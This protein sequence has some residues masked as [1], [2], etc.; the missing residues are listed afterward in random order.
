MSQPPPLSPQLISHL[1]A[2]AH[3][4]LCRESCQQALA[5]VAQEREKLQ[6]TRPVFAF[7]SS[8]KTKAN[9][10]SSEQELAQTERQVHER[11]EVVDRIDI[12]VRAEIRQALESYLITASL[13]YQT[14]ER[15]PLVLNRWRR[16]VGQLSESVLAVARE[17]RVLSELASA[18]PGGA[19]L[20]YFT[21]LQSAVLGLERRV[22][23]VRGAANDFA[24]LKQ[25]RLGENVA[26]PVL[27]E[28]PESTWVDRLLIKGLAANADQLP[29]VEAASR[30]FCRTGVRKML[31]DS[32]SLDE[33]C[34]KAKTAYLEHYWEQLR[35]HTLKHLPGI[36]DTQTVLV[37]L[38][39]RMLTEQRVRQQ[40]ALTRSPF[41]I[42]R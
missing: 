39:K 27:P 21:P 19:A 16:G 28:L 6:G 15:L 30:E 24:Q 3:A 35:A 42:A 22:N 17:I 14:L 29:P 40:D 20:S 41:A 31:D 9:F 33:H 37:E 5:G 1:K 4:V 2:E 32:Q 13:E 8:A 38:E 25:G 12:W 10:E 18:S 36:G 11:L 26:L 23:E 7:L 34:V